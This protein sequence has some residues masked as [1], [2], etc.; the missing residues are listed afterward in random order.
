MRNGQRWR[1]T[2]I[3]PDNNRLIARRLDDNTLGAFLNDYVREHITHGYAVTVH[4]AQGVTA[5]TTHAVLSET[6]TRTLSYVAMTRGRDANTVYLYERTTE[7]EHGRQQ[8]DRVHTLQRGTAHHAGQLIRAIIANH[9]NQ[10]ITAH[11]TAAQ[12]VNTQLP[13]RVQNLL[14]RKTAAVRRRREAFQRWRAKIQSYTQAMA[15]A[16]ERHAERSQDQGLDC[17]IEI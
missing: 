14:H 3:N 17:G 10:L 12:S 15:E 11:D 5:D 2:R 7:H 16:Q 1:V 13:E 6:G 8:S 9:D 4:S